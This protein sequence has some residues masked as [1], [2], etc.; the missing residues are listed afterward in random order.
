[1]K[2]AEALENAIHH[3]IRP[4]LNE[5]S[6]EANE[7][8]RQMRELSFSVQSANRIKKM[9]DDM[10]KINECLDSRQYMEASSLLKDL[11]EVVQRRSYSDRYTIFNIVRGLAELYMV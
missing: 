6:K 3:H 9:Y 11:E 7:T 5:A 8:V 2:E 4:G 10:E 1:M